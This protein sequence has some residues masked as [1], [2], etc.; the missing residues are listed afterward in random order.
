MA[1]YDE[2]LSLLRASRG[3]AIRG[4]DSREA[5]K[6]YLA[7]NPELSF[8]A[9]CATGL[10]GCVMCGHDGRRSFLQHLNVDPSH[11][12]RGIGTALVGRCLME[13]KRLGIDKTHIDVSSPMRSLMSTGRAE[14]GRGG[15]TSYA[16]R[17]RIR[18]IRTPEGAAKE[19]PKTRKVNFAE[20]AHVL[21]RQ[22]HPYRLD[23][24]RW[25]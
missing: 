8:A 24:V 3:I 17:L 18:R 9:R 4:A 10:V 22:A 14:S 6:R 25:I 5:T 7:R 1:Y 11:Q 2:M 20:I 19:L 13:F 16:I 12:R 15:P 23:N 21:A